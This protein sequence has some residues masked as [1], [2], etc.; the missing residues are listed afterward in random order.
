MDIGKG[1]QGRCVFQSLA[2]AFSNAR[3]AEP[4]A[5]PVTKPCGHRFLQGPPVQLAVPRT[6]LS[7]CFSTIGDEVAGYDVATGAWSTLQQW[8]R[9]SE[10]CICPPFPAGVLR[11]DSLWESHRRCATTGV[12]RLLHIV[13]SGIME[14]TKDADT[15]QHE[16]HGCT[17]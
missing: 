6:G 17:R 9:E 13:T 10:L 5:I 16:H 1:A 15:I 4:V 8:Y 11:G 2:G 3:P 7:R 12:I 14:W